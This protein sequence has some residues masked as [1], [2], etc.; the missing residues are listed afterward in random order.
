M[1]LTGRHAGTCDETVVAWDWADATKGL[2][3]GSPGLRWLSSVR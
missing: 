2:M 1:A 3:P